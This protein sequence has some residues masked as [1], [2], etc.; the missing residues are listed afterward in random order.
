ML[1]KRI[2]FAVAEKVTFEIVDINFMQI[3]Q[4]ESDMGSIRVLGVINFQSTNLRT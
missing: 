3:T 4:F 1:S 2:L